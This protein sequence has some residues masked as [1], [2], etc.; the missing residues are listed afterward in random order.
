MNNNSSSKAWRSDITGLRALAVVP[1][2][3]FHAFPNLIPGGFLGVDIFF[4]ISGFLISGIIFRGLERGEFSFSQFYFNRVRRILPNLILVLIFVIAMGWFY[5]TAQEY[6]SLIQHTIAGAFFYQNFQLLRE[7][8]QYFSD[9]S[10]RQPLLHL[11]SLAIEEQFYIFFPVL[12]YIIY[13]YF[14]FDGLKV[15]VFFITI[16]SFILGI[17]VKDQSFG[18]YFPACR[19]WEIGL[20]I[21][22]ALL[23][24]ENPF[25][26]VN[27]SN[28]TKN[29]LSIFAFCAVCLS[30]FFIDETFKH[31]GF[32]TLGVVLS[33]CILIYVGENSFINNHLLSSRPLIF[34]GLISYSLYLWHWPILAFKNLCLPQSNVYLSGVI[35]LLVSFVVSVIVYYFVE[36]PSRRVKKSWAATLGF[37]LPLLIVI[38]LAGVVKFYHGIPER[39]I[40]QYISFDRDWTYPS[41]LFLMEYKGIRVYNTD[42]NNVL[43]DIIVFGDSHAEQYNSRIQK[44][45]ILH[46]RPVGFVTLSGCLP[47]WIE[48]NPRGKACENLSKNV[49]VLIHDPKI[50]TVVLANMWGAYQYEHNHDFNIAID[51]IKK[52]IA[53]R[54]DIKWFVLK[55]LPWAYGTSFDLKTKLDRIGSTKVQNYEME[56]SNDDIWNQGNR[57]IDKLKAE[58][59][60]FIDGLPLHCPGLKC[61]LFHYRDWNHLRDSYVKEKAVWLDQIFN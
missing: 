6:N 37:V 53:Q 54:P 16:A 11:W 2:L 24:R 26:V 49:N 42:N 31:P 33:A 50:K 28:A 48:N 27:L 52:A 30:Y 12:S 5:M 25:K 43:P 39:A 46:K 15:F 35:A 55:D 38:F 44:L 36:N 60:S 18:F 23:M 34:V 8:G 9:A 45:S 13:K 56:V 4:V 59:V 21:I 57:Y 1:V 10:L 41:G 14:K 20:G 58:N 32:V 7:A 51:N 47:W 22:V 3:L 40:N 29:L 19:F 61:D 17:V